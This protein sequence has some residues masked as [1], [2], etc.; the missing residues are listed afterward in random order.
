[1]LATEPKWAIATTLKCPI[2]QTIAFVNYYRNIGTDHIYLFFD[3]PEDPGAELFHNDNDVTATRCTQEYFKTFP[4]DRFADV[5][6]Q[7]VTNRQSLNATNALFW[8]RVR[9]IDWI[10]HVDVDELIY[11]D[12]GELKKK[13]TKTHFN[14]LRFT[15]LE[16]V[17]ERLEYGNFFH[18]IRHFK[19]PAA[20]HKIWLRYP[21]NSIIL[22]LLKSFGVRSPF[23]INDWYFRGHYKSKCIVRTNLDI[24]DM[25]VH[26]PRFEKRHLEIRTR[27][28]FLLHYDS[29][30]FDFWKERWD[31]K[32]T[33]KG[34]PK[35][36]SHRRKIVQHMVQLLTRDASNEELID[37]YEK[38]HYI[39][40]RDTRILKLFGL[41]KNIELNKQLFE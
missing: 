11:L 31:F 18:E 23:A 32:I 26:E 27:R 25:R 33:G 5:D 29:C 6:Y 13:L 21:I 19:A 37:S 3:D 36:F 20:F 2:D 41:I 34:R 10:T 22:W 39:S 9:G 1:M 28:V 40:V 8:S 30:G 4:S 24:L 16:A 17:P 12:S 7:Y 38:L 15:I 14:I 35:F